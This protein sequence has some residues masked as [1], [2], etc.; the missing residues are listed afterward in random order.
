MCV[1]SMLNLCACKNWKN[2][3]EVVHVYLCMYVCM[4]GMYVCVC[5]HVCRGQVSKEAAWEHRACHT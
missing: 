3:P 2:W 4:Y 5:G 1:A